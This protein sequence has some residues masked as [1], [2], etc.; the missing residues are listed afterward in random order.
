MSTL[1]KSIFLTLYDQ[2]VYS[3][4]GKMIELGK[5]F[6]IKTKEQNLSYFEKPVTFAN[7]V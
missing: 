1:S 6:F 3:F 7:S 2:V 5:F 4:G